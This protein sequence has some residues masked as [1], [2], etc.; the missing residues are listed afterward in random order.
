LSLSKPNQVA[1]DLENSVAAGGALRLQW[2]GRV[3]EEAVAKPLSPSKPLQVMKNFEI[4]VAAE[5]GKS[6]KKVVAVADKDLLIAVA[7]RGAENA[8]GGD[9]DATPPNLV[10]DLL[11]AVATYGT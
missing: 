1:K 8:E 6:T 5:G 3:A 9:N 11:I 7:V 4:L 10:K 2:F